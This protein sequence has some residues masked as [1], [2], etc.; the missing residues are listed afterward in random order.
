MEGYSIL[1]LENLAK[2]D[3]KNYKGWVKNLELSYEEIN[4]EKPDLEKLARTLK[5]ANLVKKALE[6]PLIPIRAS[7]CCRQHPTSSSTKALEP[8]KSLTRT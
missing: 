1:E 2:E 6:N 8:P 4:K 5:N 3:K 7:S